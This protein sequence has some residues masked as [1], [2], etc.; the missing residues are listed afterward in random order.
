M[1]K[2]YDFCKALCQDKERCKF[3]D[4]KWDDVSEYSFI[5]IFKNEFPLHCILKSDNVKIFVDVIYDS[6]ADFQYFTSYAAY[7]DGTT[8]FELE[9]MQE[10]FSRLVQC[11]TY[12]N[13][14]DAPHN[15][16]HITYTVGNFVVIREYGKEFSPPDKPWMSE[17]LTV[18]LP[19]KYDIENRGEADG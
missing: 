17:R 5:D 10:I 16:A 12:F 18:M 6:S 13:K 9:A 3:Y 15:G 8:V 11:G 2:S 14:A 19:I 4:R 1:S 7:T